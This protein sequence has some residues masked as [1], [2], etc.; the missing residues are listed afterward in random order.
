MRAGVA[1][2]VVRRIAH[3]PRRF[4]ADRLVQRASFVVPAARVSRVAGRNKT[5]G[6]REEVPG[7][8]QAPRAGHR[9]LPLARLRQEQHVRQVEEPEK[10]AGRV[11]S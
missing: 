8:P 1:D 5:R 9:V 4:V 11:S 6:R 3:T 10:L 7:A 2:R